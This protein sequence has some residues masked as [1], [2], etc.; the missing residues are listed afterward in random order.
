MRVPIDIGH[1]DLLQ[2]GLEL[3]GQARI[4]MALSHGRVE[5]PRKLVARVAAV[6]LAPAG[7][8]RVSAVPKVG[9]GRNRGGAH[10]GNVCVV[11]GHEDVR[12]EAAEQRRAAADVLGA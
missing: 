6:Q 2:T 7:G 8:A 9:W 12:A 3:A 5:R 10:L 11:E 1:G 4:H